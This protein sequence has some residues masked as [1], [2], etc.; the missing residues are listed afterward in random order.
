MV[1][2]VAGTIGRLARSVT[3][4]RDS[5]TEVDGVAVDAHPAFH[6][7]G[8]VGGGVPVVYAGGAECRWIPV[9]VAQAR[10][11]GAEAVAVARVGVAWVVAHAHAVDLATGLPRFARDA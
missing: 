6:T 10:S 9:G 2:A 7:R 4:A 3:V 8:A 1:V 11:A 5:V